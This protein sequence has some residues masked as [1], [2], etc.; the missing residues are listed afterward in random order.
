MENS[1]DNNLLRNLKII[2]LASVPIHLISSYLTGV[3]IHFIDA[4]GRVID[5]G[6]YEHFIF[7]IISATVLSIL[8]VV[9]HLF[10]RTIDNKKMEF[11]IKSVYVSLVLF[12]TV[13]LIC[14]FASLLYAD[15][16][17]GDFEF[18]L[19]FLTGVPLT[20]IFLIGLAV[21]AF[22]KLSSPISVT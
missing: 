22:G 19:F 10:V 1:K 9:F 3:R 14:N 20:T 5:R 8:L 6:Y 13:L 17:W 11:G 4:E 16:R 7:L 21:F 12:D 15:N 2:I 18:M